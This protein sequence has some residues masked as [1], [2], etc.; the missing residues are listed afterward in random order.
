MPIV[1]NFRQAMRALVLHA[2]ITCAF[3][4]LYKDPNVEGAYTLEQ[5]S[6]FEMLNYMNAFNLKRDKIACGNE[7]FRIAVFDAYGFYQMTEHLDLNVVD[8]A[9]SEATT[10]STRLIT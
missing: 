5:G 7:N 10:S 1:Q 4:G 3:G 8:C 9:T 6:Y 2:L